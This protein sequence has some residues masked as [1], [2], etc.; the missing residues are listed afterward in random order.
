[1][2]VEVNGVWFEEGYKEDESRVPDLSITLRGYTSKFWVEPYYVNEFL[3]AFRDEEG[4]IVGGLT[5]DLNLVVSDS[6][7]GGIII[8]T[9][10][11]AIKEKNENFEKIK[12]A[13]ERYLARKFFTTLIAVE[14]DGE[15]LEEIVERA[16][17]DAEKLL[18]SEREKL[19]LSME[20]SELKRRLKVARKKERQ[21]KRRYFKLKSKCRELEEENE[22]LKEEIETLKA[23]I[24][25][26]KGVRE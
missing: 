17:N 3:L 8:D 9:I 12:K 4:K 16:I 23:E 22:R 24:E 19:L 25:K 6:K 10:I 18:R 21:T 14:F 1:M 5:S 15:I 11:K 13:Y 26:L 7:T 20:M 2:W